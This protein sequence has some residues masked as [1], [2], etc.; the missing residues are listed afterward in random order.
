MLFLIKTDHSVAKLRN[1][2]KAE[3]SAVF[4][5]D[6]A[7]RKHRG[8]NIAST[9]TIPQES[10]SEKKKASKTRFADAA[11]WA[12]MC[13]LQPGMKEL[14]SK[15]IC[16]RLPNAQSVAVSD[17]LEAPKVH[18]INLKSY[19]GAVGD[20]IRIKAT[21]NFKVTEVRLKI[22]N[23]LGVVLE[24]GQATRYPRKP[25]MWVYEATV[26]NPDLH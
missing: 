16:D 10:T 1:K 15:G 22:T 25:V 6:V 11:L 14:Y 8:Q 9:I 23:A 18:Y 4:A 5:H 13:L 21:D 19:T 7:L 2:T 17:Y 20:K 12:K 3:L 26:A 24:E